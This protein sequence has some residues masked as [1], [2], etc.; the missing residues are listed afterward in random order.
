MNSIRAAIL[1][2]ASTKEANLPPSLLKICDEL[3]TEVID[4]TLPSNAEIINKVVSILYDLSEFIS[5]E[6][7]KEEKAK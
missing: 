6:K 5:N 7:R 4:V 1:R 2:D 3:M